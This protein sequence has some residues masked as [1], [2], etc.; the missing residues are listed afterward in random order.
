MPLTKNVSSAAVPREERNRGRDGMDLIAQLD[1]PDPAARRWAARDLVL[2]PDSSSVL[3]AHLATEKDLSVREVMLTTLVRLNDPVAVACLVGFLHSEDAA[4]RNE[5]VEALKE[6]PEHVAA[7]IHDLL[8]DES[9][10]VRIFGVNVL[11]SLRH[12]DVEKWLIEVIE[13]DPHVNVC[14]TAVDLLAEVGTESSRQSLER[15]KSRFPEVP[16]LVFAIDLAA[17]RIDRA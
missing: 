11:E 13:T 8:A 15:L 4:L 6:F 16:Y 12:P 1:D 9:P 5:A 10:D 2:Y 3:I 7:I 14:A 17:N